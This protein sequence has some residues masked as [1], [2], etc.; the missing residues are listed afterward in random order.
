[1]TRTFRRAYDDHKRYPSN[2]VGES[3][4]DPSMVAECDI[5]NILLRWQKTGVISHVSQYQGDYGDFLSVPQSYHEAINQVM[6]ADEA[7]SSLPAAVRKRFGNDP[8]LFLEFVGDPDNVEEMRELGL[9]VPDPEP[10]QL[11][12]AVRALAPGNGKATAPG[13]EG[14]KTGGGSPGKSPS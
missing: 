3:M 14:E 4:T 7:F 2:T 11:L 6:A 10:D 1:M 9:A 5:N 8:A 12:E 13:A